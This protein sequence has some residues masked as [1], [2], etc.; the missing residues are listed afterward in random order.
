MTKGY[1]GGGTFGLPFLFG[2]GGGLYVDSHGR[3]YPQLYGGTPTLSF[4]G[5]YTPD[6]EGL[7]TGPSVSLSPG[8]GS[9]RPNFAG[10]ADT[11]GIGIGTPG[12]GVTHGLGPYEMSND[13]SNPWR[14][15]AIR[16]SAARAGVASRY[17]VFEYGYP[18]PNADSST[19]D[20]PASTQRQQAAPPTP[21]FQ[22]D[23]VYS[24]MGDLFGSYPQTT[25]TR[26]RGGEP[27]SASPRSTFDTGAPA[28]PER[29]LGRSTYSV[30]PA[31]MF[32]TGAPAM[33]IASS[34]GANVP[35]GVL[36]SFAAFAGIDPQNPTQPESLEDD[37]Q[38]QANLR[39]LSAKLSSSGNIRDAVALYN[40]IKSNRR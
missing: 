38:E 28:V 18:D 17:N 19:R 26:R 34:D 31:S 15:P 30:S 24:P 3:A 11:L 37:E 14:I 36:G 20:G 16:D 23:A 4:S 10:N 27:Y 6:L 22:P 8:V 40:A 12:V 5:G 29:T 39:A 2:L 35:G 25:A 21:A 13:Y 9:I 7:L 1:Y 33:S 32:D